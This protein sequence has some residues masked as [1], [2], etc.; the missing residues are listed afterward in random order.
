MP[1]GFISCV[2]HWLF[3]RTVVLRL[4]IPIIFLFLGIAGCSFY[5]DLT[6]YFNTYYNSKKLF[7]DAV[8]EASL[9]PQK[10]RDT[11]YF[12]PYTISQST[13]KKFDSV[14]V[15][16]SKLIQF[17]P[18]T[19]WVVNG[20]LMIGESYEYM[21]ESEA[22]IRKYKELLENFSGSDQRFDARLWMAKAQY[23]QK[24][25]DEALKILKELFPDLRSEGKTDQLLESL[26]LQ[27]QIYVDRKEYD[28]AAQTY[29]LAVEVPGN[30]AMR[31]FAQFQYGMVLEQTGEKEKAADAYLRVLKFSPTFALEFR[32]RLRA[33]MMMTASKHQDRALKVLNQLNDEVLKPEEHGLVNLEIANTYRSAGDTATAFPIYNLIDTAYKHTEASTKSM[34]QRA[35]YYERVAHNFKQAWIYY[36]KAKIENSAP[37]IA[38]EVERKSTDFSRYF[39]LMD[40]V[41]RYNFS[42]QKDSTGKDLAPTD[43]VKIA[44][45][46]ESQNLENDLRLGD[47]RRSTGFRAPDA[48]NPSYQS[49]TQFNM[50][51]GS[52]AYRRRHMDRDLVTDDDDTAQPSDVAASLNDTSHTVK[53]D[54]LRRLAKQRID[55]QMMVLTVDSVRVLLAQSFYEL[56]ALFYLE[57]NDLDSARYWYT[58]ILDEYPTSRYVPRTYYALAEIYRASSD[59]VTVDSLHKIILERYGD[60][61]YARKLKILMGI[62]VNDTTA[63]PID[64]RYAIAESTLIGG[65]VDSA[66]DQFKSL[67]MLRPRHHLSSKAAYTVGWIYENTVH[68][69]DSATLWYK[70]MLKG[71]STSIYASVV[72][73]KI[74][75]RD[76]PESLK[77]LVK[78][79]DEVPGAKR[80][81]TATRPS[82]PSNESVKED[83]KVDQDE[84]NQDEDDQSTDEDTDTTATDDDSDNNFP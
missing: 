64:V 40:N 12:A 36:T 6:G 65:N 62:H 38:P 4:S 3:N 17:Y 31:S 22:A 26:M 42:L 69:N 71:D 1:A 70:R 5:R 77:D 29:A 63:S 81:K 52:D 20:I 45:P 54:S 9:S 58:R 14:I 79:K 51:G 56:G 67:A 55:N 23:H 35:R 16:C 43:T 60:S 46:T 37:E 27:A 50:A 73:P 83:D 33:G 7:D 66:L 15:K 76:K 84:D 75:V 18:T 59:S 61:E 11:N 72:K 49:S 21:G 74:S 41:S 44:P 19:R 78:P 47:L 13:Q 82:I 24:N 30:D 28:Q 80:D 2:R 57:L 32:T 25:E 34:Y 8:N 48:T 53:S 10:D 39:T 68:D